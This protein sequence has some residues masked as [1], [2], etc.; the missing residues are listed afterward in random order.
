MGKNSSIHNRYSVTL[1]PLQRLEPSKD[2]CW[3]PLL[4]GTV[5]AHYFPVPLRKQEKGMELPFHLMQT[6]VGDLY[7]MS[8]AG[9]IYLL[10]HSRLL[11]PTA[12]SNQ[13]TI[14][15][16][17]EATEDRRQGIEPGVIHKLRWVKI[18]DPP[19]S[20]KSSLNS[21]NTSNSKSSS[22]STRRIQ[23]NI[24]PMSSDSARRR[25]YRTSCHLVDS[26]WTA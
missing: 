18:N 2:L 11:F 23:T 8:H 9:G 5:I 7:P 25:P 13:G 14:Q 15:W 16:H 12:K 24:S 26:V 21:I 17:L 22:P 10:G 20:K 1:L 3:Y 19:R 6:L 4:R